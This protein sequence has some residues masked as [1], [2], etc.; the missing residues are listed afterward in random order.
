MSG[1]SDKQLKKIRA[2]LPKKISVRDN[3]LK[4]RLDALAVEYKERQRANGEAAFDMLEEVLDVLKLWKDKG[5][6]MP[7][8]AVILMERMVR[9]FLGE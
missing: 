8:H 4:A 3:I 1:Y 2:A 9:E 7:I 6:P 5:Q